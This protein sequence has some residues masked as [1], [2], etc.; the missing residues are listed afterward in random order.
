MQFRVLHIQSFRPVSYFSFEMFPIGACISTDT[1]A[2]IAEQR[3]RRYVQLQT[4]RNSS[5]FIHVYRRT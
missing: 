4:G 5:H 1:V 2:Y 3:Y